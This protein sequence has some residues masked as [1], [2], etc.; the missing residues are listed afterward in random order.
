MAVAILMY[1]L[2]PQTGLCFCP[3]CS[4]SFNPSVLFAAED[5][6][7]EATPPAS[8]CCSKK[9]TEP[10]EK[11]CCCK[12]EPVSCCSSGQ[13]QAEGDRTDEDAC[14]CGC[15]MTKET[16]PTTQNVT[17]QSCQLCEEL[18]VQTYG[19][20][21]LFSLE[22]TTFDIVSLEEYLVSVVSSLTVR[23]H[24]ILLVLLN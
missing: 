13:E 22:T 14:A 17:I 10:R 18:K 11:R 2:V 21:S 20:I 9:K 16:L 3:D 5:H 23:L 15:G 1:A 24:L 8:S 12:T 4:C 6:D 19:I 7:A